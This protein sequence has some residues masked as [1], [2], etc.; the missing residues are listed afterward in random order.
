M[1]L[2]ILSS[3]FIKHDDIQMIPSVPNLL[4]LSEFVQS[5]KAQVEVEVSKIPPPEQQV[6]VVQVPCFGRGRICYVVRSV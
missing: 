3:D 4:T 1:L 2:E 5:G 6:A